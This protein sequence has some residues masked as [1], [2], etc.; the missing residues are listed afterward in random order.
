MNVYDFDGTIYAGD[1]TIDF[2]LFC[3]KKKKSL[4]SCIPGQLFAA[5]KYAIGKYDKVQFK[6][7]FFVFFSKIDNI[8]QVVKMFWDKNENKIEEWY[9]KQKNEEDVVISASPEFLLEEICKR[10]GIHTL[11]ASKVDNKT[12]KYSGKNCRGEEKPKRFFEVFPNATIEEFYSDSESDK[13]MAKF[14]NKSF[15]VKKGNITLWNI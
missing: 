11:I 13:P 4:I 5:F 7:K 3:L 1:S 2:Y 8:E 12:G 6:E 15:L 9:Y 10:I 14:A